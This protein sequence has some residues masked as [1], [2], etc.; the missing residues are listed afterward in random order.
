MF[1]PAV[2][3]AKRIP[4]RDTYSDGGMVPVSCGNGHPKHRIELQQSRYCLPRVASV[5][6]HARLAAVAQ[7]GK[8][9]G[10]Y[11]KD[12]AHDALREA[13]TKKARRG[14]VCI[15]VLSDLQGSSYRLAKC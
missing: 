5:S 6:Q 4:I 15:M 2:L 3:P 9:L 13:T 7:D 12:F 11:G 1:S 8:G 14:R 10:L